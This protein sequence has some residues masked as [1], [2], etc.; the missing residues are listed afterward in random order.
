LPALQKTL[1]C[2]YTTQKI[3]I[4]IKMKW[5]AMS[6]LFCR[7]S[8]FAVALRILC[9]FTCG[10]KLCNKA[11]SKTKS[12]G[13]KKFKECE[14]YFGQPILKYLS[15][16]NLTRSIYT[17][18]HCIL[19]KHIV[20]TCFMSFLPVCTVYKIQKFQTP[21]PLPHDDVTFGKKWPFEKM[22]HYP[23]G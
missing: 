20:L 21:P 6:H 15:I 1:V 8:G 3:M 19:L 7:P 11:W 17:V 2:K 9:N 14:P 23:R 18:L 12:F 22:A 16:R 13:Y 4:D 5:L 10:Q